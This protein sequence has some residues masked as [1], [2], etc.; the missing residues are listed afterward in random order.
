MTH[1]GGRQFGKGC[2]HGIR[3][4]W[5]VHSATDGTIRTLPVEIKRKHG[6]DDHVAGRK[7]CRK[8]YTSRTHTAHGWIGALPPFR[9]NLRSV[10]D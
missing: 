4:R 9:L 2:R 5:L 3:A 10:N 1:F 6:H 8:G 7:I